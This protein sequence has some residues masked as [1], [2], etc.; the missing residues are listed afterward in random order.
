MKENKY[1][2]AGKRKNSV[3]LLSSLKGRLLHTATW[4]IL[5]SNRCVTNL[6]GLSLMLTGMLSCSSY[7][8]V[9]YFRDLGDSSVL[10]AQGKGLEGA[11]Y[12]PLTIQSDD[13]LQIIISTIDP[14]VDGAFNTTEQKGANTSTDVLNLPKGQDGY[15]VDKS[16][17]IELPVLGTMHVEGLTTE[18][19]KDSV[20]LAA[21]KL[22]KQP[23]VNVRLTNFKV[24]VLGEVNSPGSYLISGERASVLD[25][26]SL[27]GD[28]TIYGKRDNVILMRTVDGVQKKIARFNLNNTQML[29]SPY[30]YLRQNDVIYVEPAKS[31]AAS[32]DMN[33]TKT[34]AIAGSLLSIILILVTRL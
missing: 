9:A 19:I 4:R 21:S 6:L 17:N 31:K 1:I 27:A 5:I 34:Y 29:N 20:T 7:K 14:E 15:L 23:V 12:H 24:N 28:M 3:T 13:L 16:G 33:A 11:V 2:D 25:A 30:F 18:Q 8:K 10:Y 32:T 26:L 22:L